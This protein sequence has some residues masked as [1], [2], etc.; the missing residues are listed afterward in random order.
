MV[1]FTINIPQIFAYI[2]AP[3]I[4]WVI[5]I[6][7]PQMFMLAFPAFRSVAWDVHAMA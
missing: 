1:T 7:N 4:L 6:S 3:W 2:P 5:K